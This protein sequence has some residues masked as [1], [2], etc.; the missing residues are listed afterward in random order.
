MLFELVGFCVAL[1]WGNP[2]PNPGSNRSRIAVSVLSKDDAGEQGK[3]GVRE[4]EKGGVRQK[5]R[6]KQRLVKRIYQRKSEET[7]TVLNRLTDKDN[8]VPRGLLLSSLE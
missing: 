3:R 6:T 2:R 1:F 7:N 5:T 8:H 4:L